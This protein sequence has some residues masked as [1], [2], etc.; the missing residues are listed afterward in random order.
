MIAQ[1]E[2]QKWEYA[3][4]N[5]NVLKSPTGGEAERAEKVAAL[6]NTKGQ[7]AWELIST[8]S[9]A[10]S[11][12]PDGFVILKRPFTAPKAAPKRSIFSPVPKV[13]AAAKAVA[14]A[15]AVAVTPPAAKPLVAA[16]LSPTAGNT[17]KVTA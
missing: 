1:N 5:L 7:G 14:P 3:V 16:A 6:L 17:D 12:L 11:I 4:V 9:S 10:D 13:T 8:I 15:V 2:P